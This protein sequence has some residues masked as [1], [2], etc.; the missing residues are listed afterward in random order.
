[1]VCLLA[2]FG[3]TLIY[4]QCGADG[5]C[6]SDEETIDLR[7]VV[8]SQVARG[9]SAQI[10]SSRSLAMNVHHMHVHLGILLKQQLLLF[11]NASDQL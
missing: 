8:N 5:C 3:P 10:L 11:I 1:M 9:L 2:Q 6:S 7:R 4:G